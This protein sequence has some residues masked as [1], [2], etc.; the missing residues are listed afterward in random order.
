MLA[1]ETCH[2]FPTAFAVATNPAVVHT[3]QLDPP[4]VDQSLAALVR[5]LLTGC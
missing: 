1:S 3:R 2:T 4:I 5:T